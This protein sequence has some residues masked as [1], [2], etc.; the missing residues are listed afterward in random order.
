MERTDK[1]DYGKAVDIVTTAALRE[2]ALPGLLS[3][4]A[5]LI[6]GFLWGPLALGGLLIG[7]IAS[8][9]MLAL[10]MSNGGGAW[11]NAKKYIE[12]GNHGG[13][14]SEAQAAAEVGDTVGEQY[15][16]PAGPPL[17]RLVMV[18][19]RVEL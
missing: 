5:P 10:S 9:L 17:N 2:M 18:I 1:P 16:D 14:D 3:V 8:G 11:D 7:V 4:A 12:D 15:K 19:H 13:K 6:V